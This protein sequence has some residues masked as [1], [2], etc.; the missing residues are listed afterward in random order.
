[1]C[2]ST[3]RCCNHLPIIF[4][5]ISTMYAHEFDLPSLPLPS[6]TNTLALL[7]ST[8]YRLAAH[9]LPPNPA[10]RCA[11]P[12]CRL[13]LQPLAT[14]LS[15]SLAHLSQA[16]PTLALAQHN[17]VTTTQA[18]TNS[19]AVGG[20]GSPFC[21]VHHDHHPTTGGNKRPCNFIDE[22]WLTAAYLSDRG[23]VGGSGSAWSMITDVG[24]QA[25]QRWAELAHIVHSLV[26]TAGLWQDEQ[27]S[28]YHVP[29]H[30]SPSQHRL[31]FG[32]HR[33]AGSTIDSLSLSPDSTH[34]L[35]MAR[36]R[37]W[38]VRV[39]EER[40][41]D[42]SGRRR[43]RQVPSST[44][45]RV[46]HHID[47][48]AK[49][50]RPSSSSSCPPSPLPL[51]L[52]TMATRPTAAAGWDLFEEQG[53]EAV[54]RAIVESLFTVSLSD[55]QPRDDEEAFRAVHLG[56]GVA[57]GV[58]ERWADAALCLISYAN[59]RL[60]VAGEHSPTDAPVPGEA[61]DR[62][63]GSLPARTATKVAVAPPTADEVD[64]SPV[65]LLEELVPRGLDHP[66]F[67]RVMEQARTETAASTTS[68][69]T[70]VRHVQPG[71]RFARL[72]LAVS[73][74]ALVSLSL[75]LAFARLFR[76]M[77]V[78]YET[79]STRRFFRGRT[80]AGRPATDEALTFITAAMAL[81]NLPPRERTAVRRRQ[82][83]DLARE[84]TSAHVATMRAAAAGKSFD[85]HLLA[86]RMLTPDL[87]LWK[88][89]LVMYATTFSLSTSNVSVGRHWVGGFAPVA[90]HGV[91]VGFSV[92]DES[93]TL[94]CSARED[95]GA[96]ASALGDAIVTAYAD[97]T[98][99]LAQHQT[100]P[101]RL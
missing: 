47:T 2:T 64:A 53:N 12:L 94:M 8:L 75:S 83:H 100:G 32:V 95:S 81:D 10:T 85:R 57:G 28:D 97:L 33:L 96:T 98:K 74:D 77:P 61:I 7:T 63:I 66:S 26:E 13:T 39:R 44:L 84:A 87:P 59:G 68:F 5:S 29:R 22:L 80:E 36:G 48:V 88:D 65:D 56:G 42:T 30:L 55:H 15:T 62:A 4:H 19:T 73:P 1:L 82:L 21:H 49:Q 58:G 51:A 6:L 86:L 3:V 20:T 18:C 54:R 89:P 78:V 67:A 31:V 99:L 46:L 76:R 34:I 16:Q 90:A 25:C 79:A 43:W 24:G 52:L 9:P 92:S 37:L 35:L 60:G 72:S 70:A 14:A 93:V 40:T 69:T 91:G 71:G 50:P 38:K 41:R 11:C 17:L 45:A 101:P 23:P 27:A